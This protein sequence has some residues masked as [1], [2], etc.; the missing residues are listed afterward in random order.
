[1]Q[2]DWQRVGAAVRAAR[3]ARWRRR[4]EFADA[5]GLS[6]RLIGDVERGRRGNY[7]PETKAIIESALL[8]EEG[9]IDRIAAGGQPRPAADGPMQ[10]LL[11]AWPHLSSDARNMLADLAERS[12][13]P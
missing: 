9:S 4:G 7:S 2:G 8:W 1:M 5:T 11:A 6:L 3:S 12:Q 10:R 13:N